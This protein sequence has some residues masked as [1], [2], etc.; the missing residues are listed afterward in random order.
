LAASAAPITALRPISLVDSRAASSILRVSW[1]AFR[2]SER[3]WSPHLWKRE[4]R[5]RVRDGVLVDICQYTSL[6]AGLGAA[7]SV[8][9]EALFVL[10][11]AA[12]PFAYGKEKGAF[13]FALEH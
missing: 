6:A 11:S 3:S 5:V 13:A 9:R 2:C 4:G 7:F 1:R 12:S 8:F 10:V